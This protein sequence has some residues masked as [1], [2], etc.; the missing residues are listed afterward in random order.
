MTPDYAF[1]Y[2]KVARH[3]AAADALL[4]YDAREAGK[5]L[6]SAMTAIATFETT[7]ITIATHDD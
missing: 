5:E 3:V 6:E 4:N 2:A 7:S 1:I